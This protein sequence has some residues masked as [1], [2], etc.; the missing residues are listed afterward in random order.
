M[1]VMACSLGEGSDAVVSDFRARH[2]NCFP[3]YGKATNITT[4]NT[5]DIRFW[6]D[7]IPF[8]IQAQQTG[9]GVRSSYR[10]STCFTILI[11]VQKIMRSVSDLMSKFSRFL[12][13]IRVS[14]IFSQAT[15]HNIM[16][17][18]T[19]HRFNRYRG[20]LCKHHESR[21]NTEPFAEL[22]IE[23][24]KSRSSAT[25]QASS[26]TNESTNLDILGLLHYHWYLHCIIPTRSRLLHPSIIS[27]IQLP[28]PV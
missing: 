15:C 16:S 18:V 25:S 10:Y 13:K 24:V 8:K 23:T 1:V 17:H 12:R 6:K 14:S 27:T 3:F 9:E 20:S 7:D 4:G 22:Q 11:Y 26:N 21:Q 5:P 28:V 2:N 19:S